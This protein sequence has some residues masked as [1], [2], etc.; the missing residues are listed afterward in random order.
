MKHVGGNGFV[1]IMLPACKHTYI[2]K[3]YLPLSFRP[4]WA[5][6]HTREREHESAKLFNFSAIPQRRTH[7]QKIRAAISTP[8]SPPG[9]VSRVYLVMYHFAPPIR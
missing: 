8:N 6:A 9:T 1:Y 7:M 3:T 2:H 5:Y 4:P